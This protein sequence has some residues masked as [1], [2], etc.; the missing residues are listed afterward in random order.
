MPFFKDPSNALHFLD[1][2]TYSRL[3]PAGSLQI[4]DAEASIIR[5]PLSVVK[6][7]K[8]TSLQDNLIA[9]EHATITVQGKLFPASEE[10]QAKVS[11]TL[12]YIGRGKPLNLTNAWRDGNAQPVVMNAT[13]LGQIEDAIIA[14]GVAAWVRYWARYDAVNA[15]TTVEVVNAIVW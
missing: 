5:N 4:T 13:L 14:Q 1:D 15:A 6:Q 9:A 8:L 7:E 11:R 3:L 12:N 2:V 10:F